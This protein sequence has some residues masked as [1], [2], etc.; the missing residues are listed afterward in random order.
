[1]G[2][3]CL[4]AL[5]PSEGWSTH[6]TAGKGVAPLGNPPADPCPAGGPLD[7]E[8]GQMASKTTW[9]EVHKAYQVLSTL[10][11]S[12]FKLDQ[13]V[14]FSVGIRN[15]LA[16]AYPAMPLR[17]LS[18]LFGWLTCRRAYLKACV[19]GAARYGLHG[20]DGIVTEHQASYARSRFVERNERAR[21]KWPEAA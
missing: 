14:P 8:F 7:K 12:L 4:R 16:A 15:E 18:M 20:E 17:T 5:P 6:Y 11:P 21:D 10:H 9:A 19:A 2:K 13:P 3:T 1:M